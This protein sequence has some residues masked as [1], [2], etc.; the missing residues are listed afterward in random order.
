MSAVMGAKLLS[1]LAL[2]AKPRRAEALPAALDR[3][4]IYT[5]PTR[6]GMFLAALLSTMLLGALNY[7]NNPALLLGFLLAASAQPSL[8][9]TH[10]SLSGVRLCG[11]RAAPVHPGDPLARPRARPRSPIPPPWGRPP[12]P[13]T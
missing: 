9:V 3:H 2:M 11:A 6:F 8:H 10:L 4:R 7:N 1:R 13:P 12:A 5:L